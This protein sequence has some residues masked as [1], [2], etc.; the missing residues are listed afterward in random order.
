MKFVSSQETQPTLVLYNPADPQSQATAL[1][2]EQPTTAV[3]ISHNGKHVLVAR[4]HPAPFLQV[5][6]SKSV[7]PRLHHP[8]ES[9][10]PGTKYVLIL[11]KSIVLSHRMYSCR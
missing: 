2:G 10:T 6:C 4:G 1:K 5:Y 3:A 8:D 9:T 11:V 7:R